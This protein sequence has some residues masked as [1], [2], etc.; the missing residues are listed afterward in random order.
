MYEKAK[1]N[2][3]FGIMIKI[4]FIKKYILKKNTYEQNMYNK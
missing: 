1:L 4:K 3:K 2:K